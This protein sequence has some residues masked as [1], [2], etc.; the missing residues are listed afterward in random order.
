MKM[1][2][3]KLIIIEGTDC[4]GKET[5]STKLYERLRE[6]NK[7]IEKRSFPNYNSP[8]GKIVGGPY[9]GKAYISNGWFP[10]GAMNV[11]PKVASLYY[12]ADRLYNIEE[13]N[14]LLDKGYSV[15]LD[16]YT[17]SNMAHQ[18]GKIKSKKERKKMYEWLDSLEYQLVGLPKP[19]ITIFLHLPYQHSYELKKNRKES[20][21]QHEVSES[22]LKNAEMAYLEL[23]ELYNWHTI[24]CIK[25]DKLRSIN[26]INNEI[27]KIINKEIN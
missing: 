24:E 13:I 20:A 10:E 17:S 27:M 15:I 2:K 1:A 9:L 19:D 6:E 5:Q 26:N 12:T 14:K 23:A 25:N 18:G 22:H 4:S 8:T 7:K 16:R 3:G 11:N 21:D